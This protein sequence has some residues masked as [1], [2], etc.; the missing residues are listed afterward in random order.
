MDDKTRS[1]ITA[2]D[3]RNRYLCKRIKENDLSAGNDIIDE[4][5]NL[6]KTV[7]QN[8]GNTMVRIT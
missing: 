6:I 8:L 7:I 3:K 2:R 1:E 5:E 4:N